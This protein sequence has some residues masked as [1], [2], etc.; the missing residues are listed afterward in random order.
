ME[1]QQQFLISRRDENGTTATYEAPAAPIVTGLAVA[2]STGLQYKQLPL[3]EIA[4]LFG[5]HR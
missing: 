2:K 3:K 4:N 1:L 5:V